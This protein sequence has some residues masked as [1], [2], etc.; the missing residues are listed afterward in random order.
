MNFNFKTLSILLAGSSLALTACSSEEP[1]GNG[2][3]V[4]KGEG[5]GYMSFTIANPPQGTRADEFI[6]DQEGDK[7][8]DSNEVFNNGSA[9]EYAVCPNNLANAAFFFDNGEFFGMSNLQAFSDQ[10]GSH[11]SHNNYEE[12]YYTYVTKWRDTD[13]EKPN[14][15]IVVLNA[16]PETLNTL[17]NSMTGSAEDINTLRDKVDQVFDS[18]GVYTY[19]IYNYGGEK[20]FTMSNSVFFDTTGDQTVNSI[21]PDQV[22]ES[23]E[24]ALANPVT[25]YVERLL[26]K[27]QLFL[28]TENTELTSDEVNFFFNPF[29]T[30]APDSQKTAAE[31]NYVASY[32]GTGDDPNLDYPTYE[33]V[34]WQ[35]Y[36]VNWG[37]NGLEK[38]ARLVKDVEGSANYFADWNAPIYH[39]S[40]WALSPDYSTTT[41]FT[42]QY[43]PTVMDPEASKY[44]ETFFGNATFDGQN[45]QLNTLHYVSFKDLKTRAKYKYTAE[46]TYN[47]A[48]GLKGY[49]PY[50]YASH[51]LI[52]AQLVLTGIDTDLT[53]KVSGT[54]ELNLGDKYYAYNYFWATEADYIRYAYRRMATQV[55]DG[56]LHTMSVP[57]IA[58]G[59]T[60]TVQGVSDGFLY[61]KNMNGEYVKLEVADAAGYF[62]T[63]PAQTIHGDGKRALSLNGNTTLAIRTGEATYQDL[64]A[65]QID[66]MIAYYSEPVRHYANSA[67]YYAIPIQHK[68]GKSYGPMVTVGRDVESYNL[69]QFGTVRNH[70][71]RLSIT[72]IGSIGTSIDD[73]DQPIIPDPEDEYYVALEIVIV[74][75]HVIDN[76]S[77][78]L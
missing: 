2:G 54:N 1:L 19:G 48:E 60:Q 51:Y 31:V 78:D 6:Y 35:A 21:T 43:R 30:P 38:K 63:V 15:V 74:P 65:D 41:G 56:A 36:I 66:A 70:W 26:A 59:A 20:Y 64:T 69:G 25:V 39:R 8:A 24:L 22:C 73:P 53:T 58:G 55:T 5:I 16:D 40:Y 45:D 49:G 75:W 4:Q 37:I 33:T 42:T 77:V 46:R 23:A 17:A 32:P 76:G 61:V 50:R 62:T 12:K 47:A 68:L 72:S 3:L 11:E 27:Y 57:G 44:Q 18:N 67:M 71:Y 28:G 10:Q 13:S 52:G 29:A 34:K 9:N 14:Q 7:E